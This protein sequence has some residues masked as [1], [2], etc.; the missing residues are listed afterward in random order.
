[1]TLDWYDWVLMLS[2]LG[3]AIW[4]ACNID[5]EGCDECDYNCEQGRYCRKGRNMK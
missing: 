5:F 1:M 4:V 2:G 3:L